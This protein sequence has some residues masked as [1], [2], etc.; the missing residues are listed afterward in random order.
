MKLYVKIWC[1][2]CI[3]AIDWLKNRGYTFEQIDVLASKPA[4]DR[5]IEF[6]GQ[7]K[8]PTLELENGAMLPDFDVRQLEKFLAEHNIQPG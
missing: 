2:W 6:S 8:T 7:R 1:P 4:Y 3:D 5:M